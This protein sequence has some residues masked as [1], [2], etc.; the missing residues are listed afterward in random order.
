ME[1]TKLEFAGTSYA[2]REELQEHG[3]FTSKRHILRM[4][5]TVG[6]PLLA[7]QLQEILVWLTTFQVARF[8]HHCDTQDVNLAIP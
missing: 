3:A 1:M 7:F 4:P 5:T 2:E 6:W 8:I